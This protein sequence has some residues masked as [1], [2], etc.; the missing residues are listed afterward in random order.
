MK[1]GI[2]GQLSHWSDMI[3][4]NFTHLA[5]LI[6]DIANVLSDKNCQC[7]G[8]NDGGCEDGRWLLLAKH[9]CSGYELKHVDV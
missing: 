9:L 3:C 1:A 7:A 4:G 6:H 5:C 2:A 8:A